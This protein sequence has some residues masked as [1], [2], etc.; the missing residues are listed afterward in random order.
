[1]NDTMIVDE[2]RE[3]DESPYV[4]PFLKIT[5]RYPDG[6]SFQSVELE[7]NL[8][9]DDE[10]GE[11]DPAAAGDATAAKSWLITLCKEVI[12]SLRRPPAPAAIVLSP[13]AVQKTTGRDL[14]PAGV[15]LGHEGSDR[16]TG[17]DRK[18]AL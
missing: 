11:Y 12:A 5:G 15:V 9:E 10:V 14:D 16:F 3:V 4:P 17:G 2:T 1:M 18:D 13:G 8:C 6:E 7:I